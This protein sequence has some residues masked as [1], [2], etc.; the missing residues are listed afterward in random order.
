MRVI[1]KNALKIVY[2][3]NVPCSVTS[4]RLQPQLLPKR[5]STM[6]ADL[7]ACGSTS[8]FEEALLYSVKR[9]KLHS[10]VSLKPEQRIEA[11]YDRSDVFVWLPTGFGKSLCFQTLPFVMDHKLALVGSQK[12]SAVLVVSPLVALMVDQV[13][14]LR[15]CG[16]KASI[17]TSGTGIGK[18]F[19]SSETSLTTDSLFY[20][21]P[22]ALVTSKWRDLLEKPEISSRIVAVVV[23]EAHCV[24]KW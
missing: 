8:S 14:S 6:T 19:L 9:L 7:S 18:E 2:F 13:R 15:S 5:S 1:S 20:C 21:A 23:D 22:E 16:V 12:S 11:V 10:K 4:Q 24:S 3:R 17:I